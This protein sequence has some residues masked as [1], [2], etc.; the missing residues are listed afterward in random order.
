[1][2]VEPQLEPVRFSGRI[3]TSDAGRPEMYWPGTSIDAV[4]EG[5]SLAV[6]LND[7]TGKPYYNVVIDGNDASPVVLDME[8][9]RHTYTV[10]SNLT[11][12]TH[13]VKLFRRTEGTDGPTEF[14]GFILDEK[15]SLKTPSPARS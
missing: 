15:A 7:E 5:T 13:S 14:C 1:M 6:V 10:A 9:G 12:G 3:G 4:F 11:A 8:P 2:Y